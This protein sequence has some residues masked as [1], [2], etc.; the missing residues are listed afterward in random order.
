MANTSE[1]SV[2][3]Y[4]RTWSFMILFCFAGCAA[5][6]CLSYGHSCWGGH[7]KRSGGHNAN[8]AYF[9]TS[10]TM[11]DLQQEVPSFPKEQWVLSRL[12]ARPLTSNKYR[13]RWDRPFKVKT[14]LPQHWEENELNAHMI[15]DE[16]IRD[17]NNNDD[18]DQGKKRNI[19]D[20]QDII[21]N[22]NDERKEIPGIL[23]ISNNGD[24]E[25]GSK[26]QNVELFKFLSDTN[27]NFK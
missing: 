22:I 4:I 18:T 12:I 14:H 6:S 20:M 24:D 27:D 15:N 2:T 9:V 21:G 7:G 19:K 10:K 26:P 13:G 25:Q 8:N 3:I 1:T 16:P 17:Q 23:L 5:G 11:S